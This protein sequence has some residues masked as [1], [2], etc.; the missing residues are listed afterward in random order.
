MNT[1]DTARSTP[2]HYPWYTT[3][4]QQTRIL[5]PPRSA[6][7]Y[8]SLRSLSNASGSHLGVTTSE[9]RG[10]NGGRADSVAP[11]ARGRA[12][13][14]RTTT[15]GRMPSETR[16]IL[17]RCAVLLHQTRH[18]CS[19]TPHAEQPTKVW[20]SGSQATVNAYEVPVRATGFW[21]GT[22]TATA[23]ATG[24]GTS[25]CS[26]QFGQQEGT[27]AALAEVVPLFRRPSGANRPKKV[28]A[29]RGSG[30]HDMCLLFVSRRRG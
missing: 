14:A 5:R 1:F 7:C 18:K 13:K 17:S 25:F 16:A 11:P 26:V 23:T 27:R 22:A 20:A 21:G 2:K 15:S 19:R 9:P 4:L 12:Q 10:S 3:V 24:S 28:G 30:R 6:A 29:K 8:I